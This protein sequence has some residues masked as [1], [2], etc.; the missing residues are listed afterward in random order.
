MAKTPILT[1]KQ[2]EQKINRIAY[3]IYE[4]NY[5]EKDILIAGIAPNGYLLA[6]RIAEVLQKLS[7]IKTKLIEIVIDKED[8]LAADIKISVTDKELK[9]K[10]I[11]LVDDVLNSG[12]TL[13]FG[14]KPFLITPVK[15]LTTVVLVDRGHNR[16]PIKA[17]L[18]GLSLST[19][20]QE[21][22]TVELTKGKEAVYLS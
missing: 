16:Y 21:H 22:I 20:L 12:K 3:Q 9:N 14:A 19:T 5:D 17:D 6:K 7:P 11:I 15:R 1:G 18:V 2:I 8:P 4:N 13:I 10:V